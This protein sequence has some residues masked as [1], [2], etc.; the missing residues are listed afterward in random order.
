MDRYPLGDEGW[1][2]AEWGCAWPEKRAICN[3]LKKYVRQMEGD[4]RTRIGIWLI[5]DVE[6]VRNLQEITDCG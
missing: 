2:W 5:K 3:I 6:D 1:S 4:H